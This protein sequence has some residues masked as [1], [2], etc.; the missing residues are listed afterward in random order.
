MQII[1]IKDTLIIK[2]QG[3]ILRRTVAAKTVNWMNRA[4]VPFW[5]TWGHDSQ[6]QRLASLMEK[7]ILILDDKEQYLIGASLKD[8]G[9][10]CFG[11]TKMGTGEIAGIKARI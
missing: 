1:G 9:K 11:F 8:L 4:H 5:N 2:V 3:D 6:D 10:K 7:V